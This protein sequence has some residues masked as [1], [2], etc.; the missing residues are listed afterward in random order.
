VVALCAATLFR[1]DFDVSGTRL[2]GLLV[3]AP[4][5]VVLHVLAGLGCGLYT[6]RSRFGSFDEV[7]SLVRSVAVTAV[8]LFIVN[9]L[10]PTPAGCRRRPPPWAWPA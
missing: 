2:D 9:P 4:A 3:L 10:A 7:V 6:G 5:A 1:Y 8:V